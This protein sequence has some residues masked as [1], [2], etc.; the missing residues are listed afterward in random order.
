VSLLFSTHSSQKAPRLT[1]GT[2]PGSQPPSLPAVQRSAPCMARRVLTGR[3]AD[4]L[5]C[6]G[7]SHPGLG[8]GLLFP[9]HSSHATPGLTAV[10]YPGRGRRGLPAGQVAGRMHGVWL[11]HGRESMLTPK[12]FATD[13]LEIRHGVCYRPAVHDRSPSPG[14]PRR[15]P[16]APGLGIGS[17]RRTPPPHPPHPR[18]GV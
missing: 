6:L 17:V 9:S 18:T 15:P 11:G 1:A 14:S 8:V 2:D 13:R 12:G 5:P 7:V 3:S 4:L 10:V 16:P